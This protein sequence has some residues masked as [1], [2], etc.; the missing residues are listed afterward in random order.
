[1]KNILNKIKYAYQRVIR[2]WDER[3]FW[4][5][6]SYFS[7]FIP[8][9]KKFCENELKDTEIM[10]YNPLRKDVFIETLRLIKNFNEMEHKT[11]YDEIN[12]INELWSYFG[13]NI[14]YYWN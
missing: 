8:P 3:I 14:G 12:P 4:E 11:I 13:K 1:M 10:N 9:L 2:G 6:D 5:F 7:Q